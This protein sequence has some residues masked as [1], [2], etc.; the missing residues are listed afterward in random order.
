MTTTPDVKIKCLKW[1]NLTSDKQKHMCC[2]MFNQFLNVKC[3]SL[4]KNDVQKY[5]KGKLP[6]HCV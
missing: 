1:K 6:F 2:N 5:Q 4:K 3:T